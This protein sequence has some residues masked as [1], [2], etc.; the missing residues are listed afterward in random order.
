MKENWKVRRS[1]LAT[2]AA[3]D[4]CVDEWS[5]VARPA[6]LASTGVKGF[7]ATIMMMD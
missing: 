6:L 1:H 2:L 7:I 4:G 5:K 3:H